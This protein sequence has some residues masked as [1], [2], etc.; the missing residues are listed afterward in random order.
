M[1]RLLLS[2]NDSRTHPRTCSLL[3]RNMSRIEDT[4]LACSWMPSVGKHLTVEQVDALYH[5]TCAEDFTLVFR[6]SQ[7]RLT[8]PAHTAKFVLEHNGE[9]VSMET[10]VLLLLANH[11]FILAQENT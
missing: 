7:C 4:R 8:K 6:P 3:C 5:G 10:F 1:P 11:D 9:I 2:R